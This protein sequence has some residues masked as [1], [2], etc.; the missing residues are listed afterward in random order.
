MRET[1]REAYLFF[2]SFNLSNL[3]DGMEKMADSEA[4]KKADKPSSRINKA[5]SK[6]LKDVS[7]ASTD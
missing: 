4:E 7:S 3:K 2:S 1:S 6:S 5:K